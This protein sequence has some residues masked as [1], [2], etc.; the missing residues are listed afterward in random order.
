MMMV[1]LAIEIAQL[2]LSTPTGNDDY[3]SGS[4][5]RAGCEPRASSPPDNFASGGKAPIRSGLSAAER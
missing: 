5:P 1:S 4:E 3:R 2:R